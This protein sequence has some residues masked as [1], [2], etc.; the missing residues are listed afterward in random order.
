M[1]GN[2]RFFGN[3][4]GFG[5]R[6][7]ATCRLIRFG[8]GRC[9][10]VI[11]MDRIVFRRPFR[12]IAVVLPVILLRNVFLGY[13]LF[14]RFST[15]GAFPCCCQYCAPAKQCRQAEQHFGRYGGRG[16]L[17][18]GDFFGFNRFERN[19]LRQH[20][21]RFDSGKSADFRVGLNGEQFHFSLQHIF[22]ICDRRIFKNDLIILR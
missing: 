17:R 16:G 15:A 8:S 4:R 1:R 18:N 22:D 2:L 21:Y 5:R 13:R 19:F 7:L 11:V 12:L 10:L 14:L 20:L 9:R 3:G 6:Y